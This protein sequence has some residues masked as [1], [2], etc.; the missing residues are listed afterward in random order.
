[1]SQ[2]NIPIL[3]FLRLFQCHSIAKKLSV[4]VVNL[5]SILMPTRELDRDEMQRKKFCLWLC[6]FLPAYKKIVNFTTFEHSSFNYFWFLSISFIIIR[7][8]II[9]SLALASSKVKR[10]QRPQT[11]TRV[12]STFIRNII[13]IMSK[14]T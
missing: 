5:L 4:S 9:S 6:T 1:M 7:R 11:A 3:R 2:R 13:D 14:N 12:T 8:H 10:M